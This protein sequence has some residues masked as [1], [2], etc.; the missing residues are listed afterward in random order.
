MS[1]VEVKATET[2]LRPCLS[3]LRA[4]RETYAVPSTCN[5]FLR[6]C[7]PVYLA[8]YKQK[9]CN[10]KYNPSYRMSAQPSLP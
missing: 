5:I 1:D 2:F 7:I 9:D 8:Q 6:D 4:L 10:H 3:P